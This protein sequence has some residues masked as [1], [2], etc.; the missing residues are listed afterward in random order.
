MFELFSDNSLKRKKK[1]ILVKL[2]GAK[3][4]RGIGVWSEQVM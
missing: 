2:S 3:S 4:Q 1:T